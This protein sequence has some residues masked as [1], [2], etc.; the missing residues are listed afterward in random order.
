M[1]WLQLSFVVV[2]VIIDSV[3][4]ILL[5]LIVKVVIYKDIAIALLIPSIAIIVAKFIGSIIMRYTHCH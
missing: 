4:L 3:I 5:V 2:N 1:Q